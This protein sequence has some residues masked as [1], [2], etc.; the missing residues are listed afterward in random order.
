M[1]LQ[2]L[3][4]SQRIILQRDLFLLKLYWY[5]FSNL[6]WIFKKIILSN[7]S[8]VPFCAMM[9]LVK[10]LVFCLCTVLFKP[11]KRS[12][13]V[14]WVGHSSRSSHFACMRQLNIRTTRYCCQSQSHGN[15]NLWINIGTGLVTCSVHMLQRKQS[16]S[17]AET[18][19]FFRNYEQ[20]I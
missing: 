11:M 7:D 8:P 3:Q 5:T 2:W 1:F 16:F 18:W 10:W 15:V 13:E 9:L 14:C 17:G 4:P 12:L 6:W 19:H 20:L